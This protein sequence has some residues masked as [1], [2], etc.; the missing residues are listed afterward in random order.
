MGENLKTLRDIRSLILVFAIAILLCI[1]GAL[2]AQVAFNFGQLGGVLNTN[3]TSGTNPSIFSRYPTTP[4]N[5]SFFYGLSANANAILKG[6]NAGLVR[7]G[8]SSE[9]QASAGNGASEFCKFGIQKYSPQGTMFS[10]TKFDVVFAG[11]SLAGT[12]SNSGIWYFFVGDGGVSDQFMNNNTL[13]YNVLESGVALKWTYTTNG[14]LT[15]AYYDNITV[16]WVNVSNFTWEQKKKYSLE[17]YSNVNRTATNSYTRQGVPVSLGP[18]KMDI[19]VNNIE[20][21]A[22]LNVAQYDNQTNDFKKM[23]SFSWYG[24]GSNNAWIF[25][26]N[27]N[28]YD[29]PLITYAYY[30]KMPANNTTVDISLL[31]NW[32]DKRDGS[33]GSQPSSFSAN[34]TTWYIRNYASTTGVSYNLSST[35][36]D[37][38]AGF[39]SE[40]VLGDSGQ[41]AVFRIP[42]GRSCLGDLDVMQYGDLIIET[43]TLPRIRTT[44]TNSTVEYNNGNLSI[45]YPIYY[46]LKVLSGTKSLNNNFL[47]DNVT[48]IGNGTNATQLTIPPTY[49]MTGTVDVTNN[50]KLLLQNTL[51]PRLGTLS[52]GSTVEYNVA[53]KTIQTTQAGAVYANL[54]INNSGG[55]VLGGDNTVTGTLT[56]T[57]GNLE[58][59]ANTLTING[60]ITGTGGT[61]TGSSS[62]NLTV[63]GTGALGTLN[64]TNG[65]RTLNN[66]NFNRQSS[67][68]VTLASPLNVVGTLTLTNGIINCNTIADSIT[69]GTSPA[70]PGTLSFSQSGPNYTSWINGRLQRYVAAGTSTILFPVGSASYWEGVK[71][72]Y[73]GNTTTGGSLSAKFTLGDPGNNNTGNIEDNGYIID[74]Y[75]S[76][77]YWA[78]KN[79]AVTGTYEINLD[80]YN[81]TGVNGDITDTKRQNLRILKRSDNLSLWMIEGSHS[82]GS[83]NASQWTAKR[84]G[85]TTFSEFTL[86]SN[87]ADNTLGNTP[88]PV[89]LQSFLS[90]INGRDIQLK[91]ITS[92]ETN[93]SGFELQR[94]E[95]RS[96][97]LEFRKAGYVQGKGTTNT[98]TS[99]SFSDTKLNSGKYKYR[100]KQIDNNGNFEY[101]NLNGEVEVGVPTKYEMSQNYPNPFNPVTKIDFSLPLDSK[102]QIV[103]YDVTGREV[104]VLLNETRSAGFHTLNFDASGLSS[105]MYIYR[106]NAK[107]IVNDFSNTK[108]M[109]MIK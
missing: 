15:F 59:G 12:T 71:L 64:F 101:H 86:G 10:Y 40:I 32:T 56:M 96:E 74:R 94:A 83:G 70:S 28:C 65:S 9:A 69:L 39:D 17:I 23:D 3:N 79:N 33:A 53:A 91:W 84:T 95:F 85:L 25:V 16:G 14:G 47:I 77:G 81:Y 72:I 2:N 24:E 90:Q 42:S 78:V 36:I 63:Y 66:F 45:G 29:T 92:S 5:I 82:A 58:L 57:S 109:L 43:S 34:Y 13:P 19:W 60:N 18:K 106:I 99:Y 7:L 68:S 21:A 76:Y 37:V 54:I 38:S 22:G 97:N 27:V 48:T 80:A 100:L 61:F 102:V 104:K 50:A 105:G 98:Q 75:S 4:T 73:S 51:Y 46:N 108:K 55:V 20:I 67:G 87:S 89:S 1:N 35:N 62:S 103:I 8:D 26:D 11:D 93:N 6:S 88:L 44:G 30:P 107:S 31:A 41:T 49:S 52:T